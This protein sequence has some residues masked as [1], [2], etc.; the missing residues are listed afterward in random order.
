MPRKL[1][2]VSDPIPNEG[3]LL[4]DAFSHVVEAVDQNRECVR[5][6]YE[7]WKEV[8]WRNLQSYEEFAWQS[9]LTGQL[10]AIV[11]RGGLSEDLNS[12]VRDPV[13]DRILKLD[14]GGWCPRWIPPHPDAKIYLFENWIDPVLMP[15]PSGTDI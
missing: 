14:S 1:E 5:E 10:A 7:F 2:K 13:Y 12:Y 9:G 3:L 15:G 4:A 11:L 6:E 8:L